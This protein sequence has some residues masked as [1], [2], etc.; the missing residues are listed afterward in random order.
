VEHNI[1]EREKS[2]ENAKEIVAEFEKR[3]STEIK[4]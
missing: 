4:R 1:W 2:L 3:L